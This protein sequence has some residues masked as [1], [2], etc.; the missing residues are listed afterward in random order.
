MRFMHLCLAVLACSGSA[1]FAQCPAF[2]CSKAESSAE[3]LVCADADLAAADRRLADVYGRALAVVRGL[4]FGAA[5][6]EDTLKATQRGWIGGRDDCWKAEELRDCVERAYL[7]REAELVALWMLQEPIAKAS[8]VCGGNPANE[9]FVMYFDTP[10]P[11]I[12]VEYGDGIEA[13]QLSPTG[14]GTRYD[15]WFGRYFWEKGTEA[16]FVWQEGTEQN[17]VRA[18]G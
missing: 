7:S 14:S 4:G 2:D 12:R 18:A 9:V 17:C 10:L 6:A 1:A 8:W 16:T 3:E 5:E 11:G 13:M 15:G